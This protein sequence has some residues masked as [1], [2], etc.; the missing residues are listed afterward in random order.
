MSKYHIAMTTIIVHYLQLRDLAC[1]RFSRIL[2][3][4]ASIR[5]WG[6]DRNMIQTETWRESFVRSFVQKCAR[7]VNEAVRV[8]PLNSFTHEIEICCC[9]GLFFFLI[10]QPIQQN[11]PRKGIRFQKNNQKQQSKCCDYSCGL[12]RGKFNL[13]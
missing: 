5:S 1:A 13:I 8:N 2:L 11:S 6:R 4:T 12:S 9:F 7:Q 10:A 3:L